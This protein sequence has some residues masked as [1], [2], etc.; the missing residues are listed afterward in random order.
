MYIYEK[1]RKKEFNTF[2]FHWSSEKEYISWSQYTGKI[3]RNDNCFY[4]CRTDKKSLLGT[5]AS[6]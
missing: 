4:I 3:E 6:V 5:F 1:K 2:V